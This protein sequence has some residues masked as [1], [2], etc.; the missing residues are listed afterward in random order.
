MPLADH[1]LRY[2]RI[3]ELKFY[4]TSLFYITTQARAIYFLILNIILYYPSYFRK[5]VRE[6]FKKIQ[7][8]S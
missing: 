3:S 5:H 8:F 1:C 2:M 4:I 6:S 7:L